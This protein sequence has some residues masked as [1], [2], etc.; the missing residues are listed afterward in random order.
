MLLE[1]SLRNPRSITLPNTNSI[2]D[3]K[4]CSS[5]FR[6]FHSVHGYLQTR[7]ALH[8]L[9]HPSSFRV[10]LCDEKL[11]KI[12]LL[13]LSKWVKCECDFWAISILFVGCVHQN[14][15]YVLA[16]QQQLWL[17]F[18]K[19]P[20]VVVRGEIPSLFPRVWARARKTIY[21]RAASDNASLSMH[22]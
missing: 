21:F 10:S 22:C 2:K 20:I 18:L 1:K 8:I 17:F 11:F 9:C 7:K 15:G 12:S 3:D 19:F 5:F 14:S 16:L 4:R 13:P 6:R